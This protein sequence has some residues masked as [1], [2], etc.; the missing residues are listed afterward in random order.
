MADG[1]TT[2]TDAPDA[3]AD[4]GAGKGP[5]K[6]ARDDRGSEFANPTGTRDAE[7]W[8]KHFGKG[9][10]SGKSPKKTEPAKRSKDSS[11]ES[12][13]KR[14]EKSSSKP[15]T[16]SEKTSSKSSETEWASSSKSEP[17]ASRETEK[18]GGGSSASS[19]DRSEPDSS[20]AD[21]TDPEAPT[22]KARD[23]Y[24]QAKKA[25]DPKE[26][27]KLYKRAMKEAFGELPEEFDDGRYAAVRRERKAAQAAIDAQAAE[28]EG[29][30][31]EAAERVRPAI[32]VM[33]QLEGAGLGDKLTVPLVEKSITVLRALRDLEGGD[34]TKLADVI[35]KATG[36]DPDEAMKRF[37]RGVKISPESRAA[38]AAAEAA[39]RRAAQAEQQI[40]DLEK[41]LAERDT[42]QTEAQKRAEHARKVEAARGAYLENIESELE[43][44]PVLKL[45]Q[46]AKRVMSYIIR[47]ADKKLKAPRFSFSQAADRI[48]RAERERV[49][50]AQAAFDGDGAEEVAAP[51]PSRSQVVHIPRSARAE[52]GTADASPEASFARI[53]DKHHGTGT[54]RRR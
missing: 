23:L 33:K 38:K 25:E 13:S 17:E 40:R 24:A 42:A 4:E 3:G 37:V 22:K 49:R 18:K 47:T 2:A 35:S 20:G 10:D 46:G 39:D 11:T 29:K 21:S 51:A 19:R 52:T 14:S 36:V 32:Y 5:A 1:N 28:K 9:T 45:P 27:R 16:G 50:A 48:V 30:I 41:R 7:I 15:A 8:D 31:R 44:H 26:A 6:G 43:G 34:Y 54:G 53:W 12:S